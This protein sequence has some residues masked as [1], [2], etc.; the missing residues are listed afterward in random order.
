[1]SREQYA[2]G[3]QISQCP[4]RSQD[5]DQLTENFK[6]IMSSQPPQFK[7]EEAETRRGTGTKVF[8]K[9]ASGRCASCSR[10]PSQNRG[11]AQATNPWSPKLPSVRERGGWLP[12]LAGLQARPQP[13]QKAGQLCRRLFKVSCWA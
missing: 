3:S 1:M 6:I 13:R 11:H 4:L 9:V 8:R 2:L 12:R 5:T 10:K 7:D